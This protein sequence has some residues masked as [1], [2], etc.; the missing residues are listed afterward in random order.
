MVSLQP[1]LG[2]ALEGVLKRLPGVDLVYTCRSD[3]GLEELLARE[4]PD[5]L[6]FVEEEETASSRELIARVMQLFPGL[7]VLWIGLANNL[8]HVYTFRT[9]PA[10]GGEMI[11]AI[12]QL[13]G[14]YQAVKRKSLDKDGG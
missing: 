5:I 3:A 8:M 12:Q 4:V 13:A 14:E 9:L 2:E 6:L 10:Q 11:R 1:L 7:P